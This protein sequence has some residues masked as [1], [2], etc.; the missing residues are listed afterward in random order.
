[1]QLKAGYIIDEIFQQY[2]N[3]K[4]NVA[5]EDLVNEFTNHCAFEIKYLENVRLDELQKEPNKIYAVVYNLVTRG[6]PTRAN[7]FVTESILSKYD[8]QKNIDE[9]LGNIS[10]VKE[11]VSV[12]ILSKFSRKNKQFTK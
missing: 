7:L 11:D 12:Q 1:M 5:F 2:S 9:T 3:I 4:Q 10:Y 8:F 6:V